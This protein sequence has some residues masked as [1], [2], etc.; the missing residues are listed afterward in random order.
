MTEEEVPFE[1]EVPEEQVPEEQ[2]EVLV[3]PDPPPAEAFRKKQVAGPCG[4]R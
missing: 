2:E 3:P 1:E 4:M